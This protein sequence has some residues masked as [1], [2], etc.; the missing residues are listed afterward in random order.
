MGAR[1]ADRRHEMDESERVLQGH[2]LQRLVRSSQ[3]A[4][5][6]VHRTALRQ[7]PVPDRHGA[8]LRRCSRLHRRAR[9]DLR[10]RALLGVFA[11]SLFLYSV[12]R[13]GTPARRLPRIQR[14]ADPALRVGVDLAAIVFAGIGLAAVLT[15]VSRALE[16]G[17]TGRLGSGRAA[18]V[19]ATASVLVLVGVLAPAW[20]ERASYNSHAPN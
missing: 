5:L 2:D 11:L 16:H 19:A 10:A 4:R 9:N 20:T 17:L 7:R 1:A 12:A 3:G 8:V 6:A 14:C 15:Q 18:A 13:L